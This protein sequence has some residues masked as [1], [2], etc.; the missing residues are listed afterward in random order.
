MQKSSRRNDTL[1]LSDAEC[2]LWGLLAELKKRPLSRKPFKKFKS[3]SW[4]SSQARML[5]SCWNVD[6]MAV[7]CLLYRQWYTFQVWYLQLVAWLNSWTETAVQLI[8]RDFVLILLQMVFIVFLLELCIMFW[9]Q[10]NVYLV[11]GKINSFL[12]SFIKHLLQK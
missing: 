8:S 9:F 3:I 11:H 10:N 1:V 7:W 12:S 5:T 6:V 4:Y 2:F